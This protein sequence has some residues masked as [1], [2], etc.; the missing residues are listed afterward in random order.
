MFAYIFQRTI[1][2]AYKFLATVDSK[3]PFEAG[4]LIEVRESVEYAEPPQMSAELIAKILSNIKDPE[5]IANLMQLNRSWYREGSRRLYK[6]RDELMNWLRLNRI[7]QL[8]PFMRYLKLDR[9]EEYRRFNN[10]IVNEYKEVKEHLA[11][12]REEQETADNNLFRYLHEY[13]TDIEMQPTVSAGFD[14]F[15][16]LGILRDDDDDD[17]EGRKLNQYGGDEE[18][19]PPILY[20]YFDNDRYEDDLIQIMHNEYGNLTFK[21]RHVPKYEELLKIYSDKGVAVVKDILETGKLHSQWVEY[22]AFV[23]ATLNREWKILN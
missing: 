17:Y 5:K 7:E 23:N 2:Q 3:D 1:A 13:R 10:S 8:D 20:K 6:D 16:E 18:L 21:R 19:I 9:L 15:E 11:K 4:D 22:Q 14:I 12:M